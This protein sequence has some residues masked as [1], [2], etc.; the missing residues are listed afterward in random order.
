MTDSYEDIIHLPRPISYTRR[1]MPAINRA[2]QFAPFAALTGYE[3]AIKETARLT[4]QRVELD[5]YLKEALSEKLRRLEERIKEHPQAEITYFRPDPK[6]EGGAYVTVIGTAKKFDT[7]E[8]R[9]IMEDGTVIP[10]TEIL[11][12]ELR[13]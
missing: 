2:A 1:R 5:E 12:I 13:L 7:Y 10:I 9:I 6:K 4:D 8:R 11:A 3:V